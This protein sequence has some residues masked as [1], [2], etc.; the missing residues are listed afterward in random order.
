MLSI[1]EEGTID[2]VAGRGAYM[3][4]ITP[5]DDGAFIASQHVGTSLGANDCHIEILRSDDG[6]TW[7]NEG[8]L[9]TTA[10]DA[11]FS[12]RIPQISSLP[13]GQLLMTATRFECSDTQLFDAD[14]EALQRPELLLY[15]SSD[16]GK[17]W[18]APQTIPV[19]LP[20]HKYTANGAGR[21]L[22]LTPERWMYP[23]ETWKPAHYDGPPDQKAAALFSSDQGR[24]WG[25]RT[26]V[27]DDASGRL[28]Y[29]DQMCAP[30]DENRIY[31]LLWT[32]CYGTSVDE[33][34][35][36]V[37]SQDQ[38]RT[39]SEPQPTN[40]RGQV[41]TPIPLADGRVAAIYNYR[42]AP[43]GVRV[44]LSSNLVHYADEI[45][46]FDAR[47]EASLA[48]AQS[49]N[50]LAEHLLIAFGKPGGVQLAD[51]D[52]L[53]WYWCTKQNITHTRWARLRLAS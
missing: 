40:L 27:A 17:T 37:L 45:T 10:D 3:P 38:G 47:A 23:F 1:V 49:E 48:T 2:C 5:L 25:E 14:T 22:Q 28:C 43:Q 52:L 18:S 24:S 32:H 35:H 9:R 6:R 20:A 13:D 16:L 50:F 36:Y 42:H 26:T 8:P 51:G 29:W 21:L 19:D 31:T 7:H 44:A 33:K 4:W 46:V 41:C 30:L 34:N 53:V 15:R 12:Y 39:W 11:S